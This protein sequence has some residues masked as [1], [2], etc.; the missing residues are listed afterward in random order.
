MTPSFTVVVCTRDRVRHLLPTLDALGAQDPAVPVLVV[1]QSEELDP[2]LVEREGRTPWLTV[3]HHDERGLSAARNIGW[4][5]VQTL[6]VAYVDDDCRVAPDWGVQLQAAIDAHPDVATISGD[7]PDAGAPDADDY[8]PVT[9]FKVDRPEMLAG[10]RVPPWRI[11]MG[12]FMAVRRDVVESHGGWDVRLG[13]GTRPFP[14]GEDVD[15]NYRLL[16]SGERAFVTP[17]IRAVHHQWRRPEDLPPLY[18]GYM[19]AWA[20][21]ALKH[22][23]T[24]DVRGGLWL[25]GLGVGDL[26][27]MTASALRRRSRLRARVSASKLRG[28]VRGTYE[29]WRTEW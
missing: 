15:F 13:A 5:S 26:L 12:V 24:G 10:R 8:L 3:L 9:A 27:R 25:W 14:A 28:L 1:E 6:W 21:F 20:G 19:A 23:R 4:R 29:G 11:G 22:L 17:Q 2:R 7:V 18:E 16:R